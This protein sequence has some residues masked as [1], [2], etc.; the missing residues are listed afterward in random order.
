MKVRPLLLLAL[1]ILEAVVRQ[2]F[3][4]KRKKLDDEGEGFEARRRIRS[5]PRDVTHSCDT[6]S[7]QIYAGVGRQWR[8]WPF[9]ILVSPTD[10]VYPIL[11]GLSVSSNLPFSKMALICSVEFYARSVWIRTKNYF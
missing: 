1:C 11:T 9:L 5:L 2:K 6:V 3:V 10:V 4:A 8:R 7:P